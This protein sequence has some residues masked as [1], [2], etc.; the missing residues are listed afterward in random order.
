ML[1]REFVEGRA[2]EPLLFNLYGVSKMGH[3][4]PIRPGAVAPTARS[5]L[6]RTAVIHEVHPD[7]DGVLD[8]SIESL[9]GFLAEMSELVGAGCGTGEDPVLVLQLG[10]IQIVTSVWTGSEMP[11][12]SITALLPRRVVRGPASAT[13]PADCEVLWDAD[14]G[15]YVQIRRILAASLPT[16]ASVF[17]AILEMADQAA[18]WLASLDAGQPGNR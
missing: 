1:H 14:E 11:G 16:E 12:L 9:Y 5:P 3:H 6:H 2:I 15:R 13:A 10:V 4:A 8:G 7:D 18:A 17:D